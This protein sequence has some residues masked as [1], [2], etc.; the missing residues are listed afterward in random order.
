[1]YALRDSHGQVVERFQ[2][3]ADAEAGLHR[4]RSRMTQERVR[5]ARWLMRAAGAKSAVLR[6]G[7]V[8]AL[9]F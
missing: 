2:T 7:K 9:L 5:L 8:I 3:R 1:M 4:M 6:G